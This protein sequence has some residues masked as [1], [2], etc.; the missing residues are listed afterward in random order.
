MLVKAVS[1]LFTEKSSGQV[2]PAFFLRMP[3]AALAQKIIE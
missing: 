2:K 3:A 1:I